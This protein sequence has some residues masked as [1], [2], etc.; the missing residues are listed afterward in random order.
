M[1]RKG[2]CI[3]CQD[4]R[5]R[6]LV[7]LDTESRLITHTCDTCGGELYSWNVPIISATFTDEDG[8]K[9]KVDYTDRF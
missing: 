1:V 7:S 6:T 5:D 8:N 3:Y 9:T 2:W 4:E